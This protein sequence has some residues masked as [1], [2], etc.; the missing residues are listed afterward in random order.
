MLYGQSHY[1]ANEFANLYGT[2]ALATALYTKT[3]HAT[4][5]PPV[6]TTWKEWI[7]SWLL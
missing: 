3:C 6:G 2:S 7:V 5:P 4:A 1:T